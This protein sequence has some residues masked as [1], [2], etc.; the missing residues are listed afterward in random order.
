MVIGVVLL[1]ALNAR[2]PVVAALAPTMM[3]FVVPDP[4]RRRVCPPR[5]SPNLTLAETIRRGSSATAEV[6]EVSGLILDDPATP[7]IEAD[8]WLHPCHC[9]PPDWGNN[10]PV[11]ADAFA[12]IP[13]ESDNSFEPAPFLI[14]DGAFVC[15]QEHLL[16]IHLAEEDPTGESLVATDIHTC[17]TYCSQETACRFFWLGAIG[18]SLQCWTFSACDTL[19][20]RVGMSGQLMAWPR[21]SL[22]VCRLADAEKLTASRLSTY[23]TCL[24]QSLFEQCDQ[25]L[26]LGGTSVSACGECKYAVLSTSY[27]NLPEPAATLTQTGN[28][29]AVK[30]FSSED[31]AVGD[32]VFVGTSA[33][34]FEDSRFGPLYNKGCFLVQWNEYGVRDVDIAVLEITTSWD[35]IVYLQW[36]QYQ[37]ADDLTHLRIDPFKEWPD[38]LQWTY[39]MNTWNLKSSYAFDAMWY[40]RKVPAD[41][42]V[43]LYGSGNQDID[44][45]TGYVVYVC[46]A[47]VEATLSLEKSLLPSAFEH[48]SS[49]HARCWQ[50]RYRS[51]DS[52]NVSAVAAEL[53]CL[54]GTWIN[55]EGTKGL[56]NFECAACIE[57]VGSGY[58]DL[59][60]KGRQELHFASRWKAAPILMK[61]DRSQYMWETETYQ[62]FVAALTDSTPESFRR[63]RSTAS[64]SKCMEHS[65]TTGLFVSDCVDSPDETQ[66]LD[67][68]Q[69]GLNRIAPLKLCVCAAEVC[70]PLFAPFF[71]AQRLDW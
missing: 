10:A 13:A 36:W 19:F 53:R 67:G 29:P 14:V 41:E 43:S 15:E 11:T 5:R 63:F 51:R 17:Q 39:V 45:G 55:A 21:D 23:P 28:L 38:Y 60:E 4:S 12:E 22:K 57:A 3:M 33:H 61:G 37:S 6:S 42:T 64:D 25:K 9:A 16:N 18:Q 47:N 40:S 59:A 62:Y 70:D 65:T 44:S 69:V 68:N 32:N 7:G 48:G 26:M 56:A 8:Y 2:D 1:V 58:K 24:H 35:S 27:E 50:E 46:P 20:R 30:Q 49:L 66:L 54:A 31:I 52:E 71:W 34:K